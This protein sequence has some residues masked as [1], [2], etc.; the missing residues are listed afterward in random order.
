MKLK[1]KFALLIATIAILSTPVLAQRTPD[2]DYLVY[3]VSESSDKVSLIRFGPQGA[4]VET[5]FETGVMPTDV[6]GPHGVAVSPDKQFYYVSLGHGRPYGSA[7]KYSAKDNSVLGQVTL[8]LF[9]ATM[10]VSPDGEFLYAVNFNLHGDMVPS[11]V[12]VVATDQM[13]EVKRIE[14]CIMPHGSRF[15]PQGTKHYSACM[16][17]DMLVEIDTGT[18][19]VSRHFLLTKGKEMG[20]TGAPEVHSMKGMQGM[21]MSVHGME[22]PKPGDVTCSPTWA[23]PSVDGSSIFVACN[24]SSE[25]VEVDANKWNVVRRIPAGAG[26]YN[27]AV[28]K[29]GRLLIGTNKRDQS[30]SIFEIK[31]GR[32]L[33]RL[34]TRRK[35]LH[36]VAVSPATIATPSSPSKA[37]AR[38]RARSRLLTS[39]R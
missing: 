6:D 17:N 31:S 14:T 19:K 33:A 22:P 30:V 2:Q 25:I 4:R 26:V 11:S 12:S 38:S 29:D 7:W 3:V 24:K 35:V 36:G 27:L 20:M 15:N 28:T 16:M 37:S 32:E 18:F 8:G 13:L 21:D 10:D 23:Q 5:S 34:K 39:K 1:L 9:P